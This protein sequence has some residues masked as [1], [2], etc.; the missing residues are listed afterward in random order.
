MQ[1]NSI[2][3][4]VFLCIVFAAYW[5]LGSRRRQ[6]QNALVLLASYVF[7]GWWDWR[8][9]SLILVSSFVDYRVGIAL[10]RERRVRARRR[11][12]GLSLAA[13][14]GMLGVFKYFDFFTTSFA[15]LLGTF[16]VGVHPFTLAVVLPVGISFYTF[17][18]LSYTIDVYRE[19]I[20]PTHDPVAF[21]AFVAFFPQLVAGPIERAVHLL[22]QFQEERAFSYD[23]AVAG[24]RLMVWG[25]FKKI[26]VA[27]GIARF[28]EVVF[29]VPASAG[30]E[31]RGWT[32][33]AGV[34]AFS[35]QIYGDFSGYSDIAIG[36]ARLFG[37]DISANFRTPYLSR[38]LR[39][40][41]ARW[42]ITLY[43]WFRDYLY[44]P[45]GGSR[46]SQRRWLFNVLVVFTVSGLWH[47]AAWT[48][49]VWGV[50]H[51]VAMVGEAL[52]RRHRP[53]WALPAWLGRPLVFGFWTFSMLF[54]RARTIG[55][56]GHLLA[57]AVRAPG[58]PFAD[59][60]VEA[61]GSTAAGAHVL[62]SVL[63]L[64]VLDAVIGRDDVNRI[65]RPLPA[66]LR[67]GLAYALV[68]W[69]VLF[70]RFGS[71]PQFLYFQF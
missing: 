24:L 45:L 44:I 29:A 30:V 62:L 9:L 56:A 8:F 38:S 46:V 2:A 27:D 15:D 37:F 20:E 33:V 53:S 11:L 21:F 1:F 16:G 28:V 61:F 42:H 71:A 41:W 7:Y 65:F 48:F 17:Q 59:F 12:L 68:I 34:L 57:N 69:I 51:G 19:N 66:P 36:C 6:L 49:V 60:V 39:E 50:M 13:N 3:F 47:G 5:A 64:F 54:F 23:Q 52:V 18:T 26:V 10:G 35:V 58:R 67:W 22:P 25:F 43:S 14:L 4:A 63:L 40:F 70:G 31:P 55:Q 32:V